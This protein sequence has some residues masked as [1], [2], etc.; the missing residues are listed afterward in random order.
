MEVSVQ[1]PQAHRVVLSVNPKAGRRSAADRVERL[2]AL[3]QARGFDVFRTTDLGEAAA[4]ANELFHSGQLRALVGV[5]GDGTAAELVNRTEAGVPVTLLA[6]GTE[7]L[8]ARYLNLGR[9]PEQLCETIAAGRV[10]Q[11]D[12]GRAN[13]R[14]FLLM[15]GCG[16]DAEAVD[17]LHRTRTGHNSY[18]KWVAPIAGTIWGYRYP[19]MQVEWNCVTVESSSGIVEPGTATSGS[20]TARWLFAFNLPCYGGGMRIAPQATGTD[21]LLDVCS[22][23]RG[24]TFHGLKYAAAIRLGYHQRLRDCTTQRVCQMTVTAAEPVRYQLD[25]DP[26]GELPVTVDLLPRRLAT[27]VPPTVHRA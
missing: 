18:R 8:L 11:F 7:N 20:F 16:F 6:A 3:L 27:L 15:I 21:G 12:V 4:A 25:G 17:R 1:S 13:G 2:I 14:L 24:F 23:S 9:T 26:G 10:A 19:E 5:G 22:F